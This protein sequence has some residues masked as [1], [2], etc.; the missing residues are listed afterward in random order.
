MTESRVPT[1]TAI[2]S[3]R[4]LAWD[5][6]VGACSMSLCAITRWPLELMGRNSVIPWMRARIRM[7]SSGIVFAFLSY[8]FSDY[9]V[10]A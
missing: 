2:S 3:A 10:C 6:A 7:S 4:F 1:C 8:C 5:C 9:G